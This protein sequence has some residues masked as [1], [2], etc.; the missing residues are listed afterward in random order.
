MSHEIYEYQETK[1]DPILIVMLFFLG[2]FGLENFYV[3]KSFKKAWKFA[4]VKFA[5]NLIG[6]GIIWNIFDIVKAFQKKYE[7]DFREYFR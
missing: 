2:W 5:Y 6:L 3:A 4:L 1:R 7:L